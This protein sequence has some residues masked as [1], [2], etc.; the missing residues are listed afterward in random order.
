MIS[1]CVFVLE[2]Y[3]DRPEILKER[4]Q[5]KECIRGRNKDEE[6]KGEKISRRYMRGK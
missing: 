5:M 3:M 6:G 1:K 4:V 2:V